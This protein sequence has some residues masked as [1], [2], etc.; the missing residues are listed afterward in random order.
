MM[1]ARSLGTLLHGFQDALTGPVWVI[2][3]TAV[4]AVEMGRR[5]CPARH[6]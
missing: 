2:L 6:A 3:Q 4:V 1:R 5:L